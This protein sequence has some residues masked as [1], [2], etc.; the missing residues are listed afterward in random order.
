MY[1]TLFTTITALAASALATPVAPRQVAVIDTYFNGNN[2]Q[3]GCSPGGCEASFNLSSAADEA[4][5]M[6][7][8][9]VVCHPIYGQKN[10]VNCI[11]NVPLQDGETVAAWWYDAADRDDIGLQVSH[12]WSTDPANSNTASSLNA[13]GSVEFPAADVTNFSVHVTKLE[14]IQ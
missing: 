5:G 1:A 3:E 14:A 9:N 2:F 8:F 6:P 13:T 7:A 10:Y 4:S 11:P 12:I